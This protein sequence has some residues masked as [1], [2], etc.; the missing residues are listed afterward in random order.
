M[1]SSRAAAEYAALLPLLEPL[2]HASPADRMALLR[3]LR[4]DAPEV[5]ARLERMLDGEETAAPR[6]DAVARGTNGTLPATAE[7]RT[8]SG[9]T[10]GAGEFLPP[11]GAPGTLATGT[12]GAT[13]LARSVVIL[14]ACL[15]LLQTIR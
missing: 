10:G 2:R 7:Y 6:L 14:A 9:S 8:A 3:E 1:S 12:F 13:V 11:A 15:L 5:V 4:V